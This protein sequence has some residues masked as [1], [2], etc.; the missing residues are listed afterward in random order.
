MIE[1]RSDTSLMLAVS[2]WQEDAL[3][4]LYR[5]YGGMVY[6]LAL[7]VVADASDAAEIAQDVFLRLWHEPER[8]DPARGSLR[9]F[10]LAQAHGR[11]VD[12]VRSEVARRRREE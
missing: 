6:G 4:E 3:A 1:T 12:K 10:L 11:A 9:S 5:R 2:R 8:F 7:R